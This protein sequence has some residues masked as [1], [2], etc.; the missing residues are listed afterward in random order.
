MRTLVVLLALGCSP[1]VQV[2]SPVHSLAAITT[3]PEGP[4]TA[5]G[6]NGR[7]IDVVELCAVD[8]VPGAGLTATQS[9]SEP[10]VMITYAGHPVVEFDTHTNTARCKDVNRP[11]GRVLEPAPVRWPEGSDVRAASGRSVQQ[12]PNAPLQLTV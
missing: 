2:N 6:I 1:E 11:S 10:I 12:P 7:K 5:I 3:Y 8:I 4:A 9:T